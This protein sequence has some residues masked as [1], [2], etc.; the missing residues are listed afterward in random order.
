MDVGSNSEAKKVV[1]LPP[2]VGRLALEEPYWSE[3]QDAR[4][5][6]TGATLWDG[7]IKL[8]QQLVRHSSCTA[9]ANHSKR[10]IELGAGSC[11]L[12]ALVASRLSYGYV[13][14]TDGGDAAVEDN[15]DDLA[16][17]IISNQVDGCCTVR[18]EWL[19]W[20]ET[21]P[22]AFAE[23][24]PFHCV[25]AAEVVY[26]EDS[27][28]PLLKTIHELSSEDSLILI[29]HSVRNEAASVAFWQHVTQ[30]FKYK[31]LNTADTTMTFEG[32]LIDEPPP[33]LPTGVFQLLWQPLIR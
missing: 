11:A 23:S 17:N 1:D 21:L 2:P 13:F 12:P 16:R 6:G 10:A 33:D 19:R 30:F 15:L 3:R 7:S 22:E 31:K 20:G 26:E 25:L 5:S 29:Y 27:V 24:V 4:G 8:A 18:A 9:H 28:L 32:G 14:A